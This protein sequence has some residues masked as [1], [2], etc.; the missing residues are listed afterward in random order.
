MIMLDGGF[1][2]KR[3]MSK[4]KKFPTTADVTKLHH[5]IM[6]H[7]ALA[8]HDLIRIY[9]Y[10]APPFQ[11]SAINPIDKS[12]VD[13]ST[14]SQARQNQAL[15]DA[16]E[17]EPYFAV[18]EGELINTGWK[19]GK[20]ALKNIRKN[21][22]KLTAQDLVPDISQKGVD[23]RIGLD[24]AW[25]ALKRTADVLVLVTGDSDFIPAMKLARKEGLL[26]FVDTMGHAGVRRQLKV[27]AD[28]VL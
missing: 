4:T 20:A 24:V 26:I 1:V 12:K 11:G 19:L 15:L 7:S 27:H 14:S 16:L 10:D 9:W 8:G 22:G 6:A 13:F 5:D 3:H 25:I 23:M 21:G 17:L 2:K 28:L 18:R